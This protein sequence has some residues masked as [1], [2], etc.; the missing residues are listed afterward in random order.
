MFGM[1]IFSIHPPFIVPIRVATNDS[2]EDQIAK[3]VRDYCESNGILPE[4]FFHD[5]TG[6]G[7]LGTALARLWSAQ[8]NPIDFGG[9][10]TNRPVCLDMFIRDQKTSQMRLM[11]CNEHYLN[12]VTELWYTLRYA[13]EAAQVRN[14]PDDVMEELCMRKWDKVNFKI[15]VEPKTGTP[16]RPGMKERTGR[17]PVLG[18]WLATAMEGARRRGFAV[19][20]LA[21]EEGEA[22]D[23]SWLHDLRQKHKQLHNAHA[24]NFSA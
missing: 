16:G 11:L 2:P 22:K 14:L 20:R 13:I 17:S 12:F 8:T 21:N 1:T 24:L 10:P 3:R 4:N 23:R 9:P 6:R 7:S 5:A 18:D 15:Q 19:S